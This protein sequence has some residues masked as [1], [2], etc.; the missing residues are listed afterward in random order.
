MKALIISLLISLVF[1]QSCGNKK[2]TYQGYVAGTNTYI[3]PQFEGKLKKLAVK[4]GD[5]VE[6][7]ALLFAL[8]DKPQ[9]YVLNE[10]T[11]LLQES[12][13]Q[14]TDLAKPKRTQRLDIIRAKIKQVEAQINLAQLRENRNQTLFDKKVLAKDS[15]DVSH[16]HLNELL[17]KK[18]QLESELELSMLGARPDIID[19]KKSAI[20]SLKIKIKHL[21][22]VLSSKVEYSPDAGVV[23]DTF[24][25]EDELVTKAKP[26]VALLFPKNIYLEFFVPYLEAKNLYIGKEIEYYFMDENKHIKLAKITFISP[27]AEYVPPLVYSRDNSDK[28]VF[29]IKAKPVNNEF[30]NPGIPVTIKIDA[31]HA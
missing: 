30:L 18:K 11:A 26:V 17:A 3:A 22:W 9:V 1:L 25:V 2:N 29:K 21:S 7:G 13:A 24:Y 15:L 20:Q 6:K 19:A 10:S 16:E 23:C 5:K 4:R 27:E 14:L 31:K 12:I 28:I 8:D